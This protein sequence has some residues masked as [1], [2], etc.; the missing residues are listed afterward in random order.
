MTRRN[1]WQT[2]SFT[3]GQKCV[4]VRRDHGAVR[5]TKRRDGGSLTL[6]VA[7]LVSFARK[8]AATG[9]ALSILGIALVGSVEYVPPTG[10]DR[11][12]DAA[13]PA[14]YEWQVPSGVEYR[15]RA[16]DVCRRGLC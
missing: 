11:G 12:S 1:G 15:P 8:F 6:P 7:P 13:L 5:D 9:T 10:G 16:A 3:T 14:P 2:S 4:E